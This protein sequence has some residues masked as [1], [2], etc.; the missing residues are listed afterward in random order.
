MKQIILQ[1][2]SWFGKQYMLTLLHSQPGDDQWQLTHVHCKMFRQLVEN[3]V[4]ISVVE[5][6]EY[7]YGQW[8]F[9]FF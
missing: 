6:A 8:I 4:M 2:Y 7:S 9:F 5:K 1:V 3:C